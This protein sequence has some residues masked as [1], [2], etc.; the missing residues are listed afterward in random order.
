VTAS[1]LTRDE[2]LCMLDALISSDLQRI[3]RPG[4]QR[5]DFHEHMPSALDKVSAALRAKEPA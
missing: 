1:D 4:W 2:L 3:S 5:P